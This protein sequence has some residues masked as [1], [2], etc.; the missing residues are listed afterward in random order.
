MLL[1]VSS[2]RI[3]GIYRKSKRYVFVNRVMEFI[4]S[5]GEIGSRYL[6]VRDEMCICGCANVEVYVFSR[7]QYWR[8]QY[9]QPHLQVCGM[10]LTRDIYVL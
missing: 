6:M 8:Y 4:A 7:I 3:D 2:A 1:L 9:P 5:E 10:L